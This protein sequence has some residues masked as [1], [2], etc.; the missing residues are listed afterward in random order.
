MPWGRTAAEGLA[1]IVVALAVAGAG[2]RA[3][4]ARSS[5]GDPNPLPLDTL[6]VAVAEIGRPGGRFVISQTSGPRTFNAI[7]GGETS[8]IDVTERMFTTLTDF[9]NA[10]QQDAPL[11]AKSWETSPDGRTWTWHLR[12]G[13][14]FSDGHPITADD[15]LFSFEVAS[16]DTLRPLVRDLLQVNGK[17]FEVSKRDSY[18]VVTRID[19]PYAL[20]VPVVGA[21]RIMPKHVLEPAFRRGTY[22][23]SYAVSTNPDSLVT[24]GPFRL[25]QYVPG[26]KTVLT[27]NPYWFGVDWKGQRLP[28]LEELAFLIVPDQDAA[29]LKFRAGES[30]AIDN[31]K[32][33]NYRWYE[34]SQKAGGFTLYDVGPSLITNFFW[35]NLNRVRDAKSG[36]PAGTPCVDPVKYAWFANPVFRRAV[37]MAVDR[38]PII[39]SV[40]FGAAVKN[41]SNT[42][43]GNVRWHNPGLPHYDYDPGEAKRQLAT[44]GWKDRN[45]DGYLEDTGGHTIQFTLKTNSSNKVRIAMCNFIRDDLAKVGIKCDPAPVEF[46]TLVTN[47]RDDFQYDAILL[48]LQGGVPPDP[49]MGQNVYRSSGSTHY[50]NVRQSRPETPEEAEIDSLI[51]LNLSTNNMAVRKEAWDRIQTL[52]NAQCWFIWLPTQIQKMPVRDG[53]GNLHPTAIPHRLLWNIDRVFVKP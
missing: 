25:K 38:D 29:D 8:T 46:N 28:Y 19:A 1:A 42:T 50:W 21:V 30:D 18:T 44:L 40:F 5:H 2:G 7:M 39:R 33:E 26:E 16:D 49:G 41:F 37:S 27:R 3:G 32:P 20:M 45:G 9:N 52:M 12:R 17:K 47:L 35:F 23:S 11:L 53:F 10:T 14:A 34:E 15:V 51:S 6:T 24:S 13:A 22:A 36:K 4:Q 43:A 31:V 48:G